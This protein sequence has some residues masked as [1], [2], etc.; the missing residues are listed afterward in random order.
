MN[1]FLSDF[2]FD[3]KPYCLLSFITRM[4]RKNAPIY[5]NKWQ[6]LKILPNFFEK[7]AMVEKT[8]KQN[9]GKYEKIHIHF[10]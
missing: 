2:M 6:L 4:C 3:G 8:N 5:L 7:K 9:G 10:H 1:T